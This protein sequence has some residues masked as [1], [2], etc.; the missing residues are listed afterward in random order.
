[1]IWDA[2]TQFATNFSGPGELAEHWA[3]YLREKRGGLT[4][5]NDLGHE[6]LPVYANHGNWIAN[7][8][9]CNGG[10]ASPPLD[11]PN[12]TGCCLTCGH[13]YRLTVPHPEVVAAIEPVLAKRP[14][15]AQNWEPGDDVER[16]KMENQR[17]EAGLNPAGEIVV[18]K[19]HEPVWAAQEW[20]REKAL[21]VSVALGTGYTIRHND[22]TGI[23]QLEAIG[24][25]DSE[26]AK[27]AKAAKPLAP[28]LLKSELA[29]VKGAI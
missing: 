11:W 15:H 20:E 8:P 6:P 5:Q 27:A 19:P 22:A 24:R 14:M 29:R 2:R 10:I 18:S 21:A 26:L 13:L 28:E 1:M 23:D 16:M 9:H 7:C 3:W 12:P 4:I 25:T 17:H